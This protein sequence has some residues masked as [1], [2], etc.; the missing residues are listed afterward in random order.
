MNDNN[1]IHLYHPTS[2]DGFAVNRLI[3]E[4]PPLD[5]NSA[6]CNLLQC[7][8]FTD[9]CM[10][11]KLDEEL[12]GFVSGYLIPSRPE[13]L[14]VWQVVVAEAGRGKGLASRMLREVLQ[15]PICNKID[16]LETTITPSNESSWA[17]FK[18]LA[19]NL[20]AELNVSVAFEKKE[21]FHG[22]HESEKLLRIGPF[23]NKH[24]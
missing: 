1:T 15:R 9:T 19:E 17:L 8:H 3:A 16:Y 11:A 7:T 18:R 14:F 24:R 22:L 12:V 20:G 5:A 2:N 10:C 6:Y 13:T 23:Y 4:S 21:H